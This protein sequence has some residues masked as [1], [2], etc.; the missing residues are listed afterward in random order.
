[1]RTLYLLRC[2][3]APEPLQ[4]GSNKISPTSI[5][6]E[7]AM[8]NWPEILRNAEPWANGFWTG[9]AAASVVGIMG[10]VAVLISHAI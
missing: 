6:M 2:N 10:A 1:M 9:A 5:L 4:K 8:I 3:R 7:P